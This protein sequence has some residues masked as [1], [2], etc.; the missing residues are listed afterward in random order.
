MHMFNWNTM[1]KPKSFG[2][3]GIRMTRNQNTTLL[4]KRVWDL[5][6][7]A[8]QLWVS[9]LTSK[10]LREG[11]L[12][13]AKG[14]KGS[15][16]WNSISK[17]L[18]ALEDGFRIKLGAGN[19]WFWFDAWVVKELLAK[20]VSWVDIHDIHLKVK[21]VWVSPEWTFE[22]LYT[23]LPCNIPHLIQNITS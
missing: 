15:I 18:E 19:M 13:M 1:T 5:I 20:R 3:L 2:G 6:H 16:S 22:G 4:G 14:R 7:L 11:N 12:F 8:N 9:I 17:V 21:E 23:A 10:Y